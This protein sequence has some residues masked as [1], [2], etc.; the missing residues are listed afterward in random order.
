MTQYTVELT[1]TADA[2]LRAAYRYIR[3]RSPL[4]AERWLRAIYAAIDSLETFP[5]RCGMAREADALGE[6]LRQYIFKSHRIIFYIDE[7]AK[8]VRIVYVRHA[9]QRTVG[10]DE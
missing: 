6:P 7:A 4:N 3:E 9:S 8:I 10:E 5:Q 2:E 1:P